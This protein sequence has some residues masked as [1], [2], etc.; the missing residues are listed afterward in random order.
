[1]F[2]LYLTIIQ[3]ILI[4]CDE[5]L[6]SHPYH[7]LAVTQGTPNYLKYPAFMYFLVVV[8]TFDN[9]FGSPGLKWDVNV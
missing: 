4:A 2:I 1:M 3:C 5:F 9:I 7:A 8:H 6:I